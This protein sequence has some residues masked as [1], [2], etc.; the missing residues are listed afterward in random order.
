MWSFRDSRDEE[1]RRTLL[2]LGIGAAGGM[3]A[4]LLLSR[5]GA[6]QMA[7]QFGEQA[8]RAGGALRDGFDSVADLDPALAQLEDAVVDTFLNHEILRERGIDVGAISRGIVELSG[9][10]WTEEESDLAVRVANTVPGVQTVVNRLEVE[11]EAEHL[12]ETRRRFE[13]GDPAL[14]ETRW[15]GRRVGMGRMRQGSQT[16]P[17]R[18]DDSQS[19]T[20]KAL[21]DADIAEWQEDVGVHEHVRT[22]ARPEDVRTG[23]DP[24][25]DEDELDN[26][27]PHGKHAAYTLDEQ[28][29]E[30][31][32]GSRVG[33]GTKPGTELRL[34]DADLPIKPHGDAGA[35]EEGRG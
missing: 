14:I 7:D 21:R 28:P 23:Q 5:R 20:E 16:E 29:E 13:D 12:E 24:D 35:P 9:S 27:D 32:S 2:T 30:L 17:D 33:E 31:R 25:F 19:Q 3:I 15:E 10:V 8:G 6:R 22:S 18:P 11:E 1:Q 26:Q 4:G 34:E